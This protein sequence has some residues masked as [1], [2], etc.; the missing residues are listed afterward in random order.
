[1]GLLLYP[2]IDREYLYMVQTNK[3][4]AI[5]QIEASIVLLHKQVNNKKYTS[6]TG[7]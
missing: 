6:A 4:N 2:S 3:R 7:R 1:M 5:R